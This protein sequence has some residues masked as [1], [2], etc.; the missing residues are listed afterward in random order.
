[1]YSDTG[2]HQTAA[3]EYLKTNFIGGNNKIISNGGTGV[4]KSED[5]L[6]YNIGLTIPKSGSPISSMRLK[7]LNNTEYKTG[8]YIS[9]DNP[10]V[11]YI[12]PAVTS[13]RSI[14][15]RPSA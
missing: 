1:M 3:Q 8:W 5:G 11:R 2:E 4:T 10:D 12:N 15:S 6:T 7:Y 13:S 9:E 14:S